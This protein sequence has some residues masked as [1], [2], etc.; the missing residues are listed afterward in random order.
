M[1]L[2]EE[3]HILINNLYEFKGY[4]EKRLMKEFP[5]EEDYFELFFKTFERTMYECSE[6]R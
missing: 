2:C 6:V 3:N 4:G 5:M 1:G